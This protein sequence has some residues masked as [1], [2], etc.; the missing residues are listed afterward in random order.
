MRETSRRTRPIG[1]PRGPGR[2]SR[3]R[4]RLLARLYGD[5]WLAAV[6]HGLGLQRDPK[7]RTHALALAGR[8][9]GAP[10]LRVGF[11]SD[12]HAGPTTHRS[13]IRRACDLLAESRA[14]VL[15]LTGDFISLDARYIDE[16]APLLRAIPAPFGRFAVLGNH[17]LAADEQRI[18]DSLEGAGVQVLTNRAVRLAPPHDD[19]FVC[20]LDDP[21]HG[22]PEAALATTGTPDDEEPG[23]RLVLMHSPDGLLAL[24]SRHF[25]LAVCGHT[26]GGQITWPDGEAPV[27]PAGRLSRRYLRGLFRL[28]DPG[29]RILLVSQGVGCSTVPVRLFAAAEVHLCVLGGR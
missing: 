19:V 20:G 24:G 29:E 5:G 26:H 16:V 9:S 23:V 27:V 25:D 13:V 7:L 1:R 10:P 15:A 4:D 2:E 8:A 21:T 18:V 14:D 17:D 3:A 6:A 28:G 12:F 22:R 11:A